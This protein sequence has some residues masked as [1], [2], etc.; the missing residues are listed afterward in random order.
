MC[1]IRKVVDKNVTDTIHRMDTESLSY[2][3]KLEKVNFNIA[4]QQRELESR[5]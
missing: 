5:S 1:L 4:W 2:V 3:I